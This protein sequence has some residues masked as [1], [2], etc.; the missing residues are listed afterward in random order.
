MKKILTDH[1]YLA[2]LDCAYGFLSTILASIQERKIHIYLQSSPSSLP[3]FHSDLII[4]LAIS[5]HKEKTKAIGARKNMCIM[6]NQQH[7]NINMIKIVWECR[8]QN[9]RNKIYF[10]FHYGGKYTT[11]TQADS[12]S[13]LIVFITS[14]MCNMVR[15]FQVPCLHHEA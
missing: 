3:L 11:H 6:Y 1:L 4:W 9:T 10:I 5:C 15:V 14:S 2:L 12:C 13:H 8:V 7:H